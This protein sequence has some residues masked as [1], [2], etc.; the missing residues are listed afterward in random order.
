MQADK[1][2]ECGPRTLLLLST[3]LTPPSNQFFTIH[4]DT[5]AT[6]PYMH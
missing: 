1:N 6:A 3:L 2:T 5:P 4:N